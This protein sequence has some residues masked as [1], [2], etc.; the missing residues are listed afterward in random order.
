MHWEERKFPEEKINLKKIKLF[1]TV[2]QGLKSIT[3]I[4][5]EARIFFWENLFSY[6][7]KAWMNNT[8]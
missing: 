2:E 7:E 5:V 1:Y 6:W 3:I 4:Y 8:K